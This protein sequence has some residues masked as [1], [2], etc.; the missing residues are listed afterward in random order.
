MTIIR[1]SEAHVLPGRRAEFL[2]VLR[3]LV[4]TFPETY[5]GLLSHEVLVDRADQMR[6]VY[7]SVWADEAALVA[8]AGPGW[9]TD[10]VTFPDEDSYLQE[11]LVLRHFV[12][13]D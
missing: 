2:E 12:T 5:E 10:P 13:D 9:A 11:P 4:A 3:Q 6:V 7:R 1:M 8:F